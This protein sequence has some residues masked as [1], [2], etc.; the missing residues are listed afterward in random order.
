MINS[1]TIPRVP[2][3]EK[4]DELYRTRV[5]E[6]GDDQND[7]LCLYLWY[8]TDTKFFSFFRYNSDGSYKMKYL[9]SKQVEENNKK[10]TKSDE[11]TKNSSKE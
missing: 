1:G 4:I 8:T 11:E 10:I 7:I 5:R 2:V 9:S 3:K 6:L